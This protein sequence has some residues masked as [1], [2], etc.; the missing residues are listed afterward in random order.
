MNAILF[1]QHGNIKVL[2]YRDFPTPQPDPGQVLVRLQAAAL[3][4]LDIW[5][6]K[7]WPGLKL[8]YPHIQGADGAGEIAALGEGVTNWSVGERVVINPNLSCGT[9]EYC[10]A[11]MDN[12]CNDWGLLGETTRGTY[13]EF[14]T[15][16]ARNLLRI[17]GDFGFHEAAAAALVFLT[18]WHSLIKR[19]QLK[20][21][22]TVLI[23]GASGG[24]NLASLQIAKLGGARVIVV[25]SGP[26]KLALAESLGA[27]HLIDRGQES[28]WSEV[29]FDITH[30][31]GADIVV[32]NV[33][34]TFP[35][36]FR[37]AA[38]GG[39]I[40]TVGNTGHPRVEIDN[41]YVF[42]K[43]LSLIGSTMGTHNDFRSVMDLVFK[44]HLKSILDQ[45]FP[46]R[47]AGAAQ[48]RLERGEQIGKITLEIS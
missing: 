29:V 18:A 3:N 46:L 10:L 38:R 1:H 15:V 34:T 4:H 40:L 39:R 11:G 24:V 33:G 27:D 21:G 32:D 25:G 14:I 16:S 9:C 12:R 30:K 28:S 23:V 8:E 37:S 44:G 42:A 17:P 43:H 7:G 48:T 19:G 20:A 41:R 5:V 31:H 45:T 47:D 35:E 26:E 36:S 13:A 22:E 6:R 2:E